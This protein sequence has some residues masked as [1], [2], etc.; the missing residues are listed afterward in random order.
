MHQALLADKALIRDRSS[1]D[2][3]DGGLKRKYSLGRPIAGICSGFHSYACKC[4]VMGNAA[5]FTI[6]C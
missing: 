4:H 3:A 5:T 6:N 2:K 1:R